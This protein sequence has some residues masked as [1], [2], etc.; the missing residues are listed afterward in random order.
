MCKYTLERNLLILTKSCTLVN[1]DFHSQVKFS[2]VPIEISTITLITYL[3]TIQKSVQKG[4]RIKELCYI[5]SVEYHVATTSHI[6]MGN[7]TNNI[8]RE[9]KA[10]HRS[11]SQKTCRFYLNSV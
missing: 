10:S 6:S 11:K 5:Y 3:E 2:A 7:L 1:L 9:K 8:V 4:G